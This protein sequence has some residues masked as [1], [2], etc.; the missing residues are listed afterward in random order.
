MESKNEIKEKLE[1]EIKYFKI[2]TIVIW[3]LIIALNAVILPLII[4]VFLDFI[5]LFRSSVRIIRVLYVIIFIT[6]F[7]KIGF[8]ACE[9]VRL[10]LF[11]KSDEKD[12]ES[13]YNTARGFIGT[14]I[15][16]IFFLVIIIILF[17][18]GEIIEFIAKNDDLPWDESDFLT[19]YFL[20]SIL[21][22]IDIFLIAAGPHLIKYS[23]DFTDET[24]KMKA[25]V[26]SIVWIV[27]LLILLNLD[28]LIPYFD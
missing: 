18:I 17:V 3:T 27:V 6:P 22:S 21:I 26:W 25:I 8:E 5:P 4:M 2:S 13:A 15:F 19:F 20:F 1:F 24:R 7:I 16:R 28:Y 11:L 14:R 23:I 9:V 10:G 12:K